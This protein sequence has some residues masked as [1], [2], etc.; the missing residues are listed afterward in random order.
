MIVIV[1]I[2]CPGSGICSINMLRTY[3]ELQ[4]E[5]PFGTLVSQIRVCEG[6]AGKVLLVAVSSKM[7][8]VTTDHRQKLQ[9]RLKEGPINLYSG[10]K[11]R[12]SLTP[13]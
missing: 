6:Y 1:S 9:V 7:A 4:R 13:L 10:A 5:I 11:K 12:L 2:I 3:L 8:A